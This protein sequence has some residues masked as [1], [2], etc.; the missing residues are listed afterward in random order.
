MTS[1]TGYP[2]S[3]PAG[4][5]SRSPFSTAGMNSRGTAPPLMASTNSK[6]LPW[7]LR[8]DLEHHVAVL[9]AAARLLD[10]LA[11]DLGDRLA[12]RLAIRDL[13]LADARLDAELALHAVDEDL[14]VQLA[15]AGDDR[16]A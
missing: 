4:S 15:H 9:A 11:F 7:L 5:V 10:E 1:T 14:E 3:T 16:L 2:A 13:R 6:P 12:D 8:L